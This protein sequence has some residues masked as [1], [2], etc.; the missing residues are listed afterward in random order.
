M[1]KKDKQVL[2]PV[3]HIQGAVLTRDQ[4]EQFKQAWERS[5]MEG[6]PLIINTP[7]TVK[8]V[9]LVSPKRNRF[10]KYSNLKK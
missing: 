8:Y 4:V 6:T 5:V 9:T 10:L 7:A 1:R 3:I 2:P